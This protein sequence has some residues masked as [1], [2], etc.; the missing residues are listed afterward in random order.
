MKKGLVV[1]MVA[2]VAAVAGTVI[3]IIALLKRGQKK[4]N[5]DFDY[6]GVDYL[7]D[8]FEDTGV[9]LIQ[10]LDDVSDHGS[11]DEIGENTDVTWSDAVETEK[12]I[13]E[14]DDSL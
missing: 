3:S 7:D 8:D 5:E 12:L 6:D 2:A 4:V 14:K 13:E 11:V 10:G 9:S 1:S